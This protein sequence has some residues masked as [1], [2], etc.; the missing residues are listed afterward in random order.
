ME[1]QE[2]EPLPYQPSLGARLLEAWSW[3]KESKSIPL[4]GGAALQAAVVIIFYPLEFLKK[5]KKRWTFF[6]RKRLP[7]QI[8]LIIS[9]L[10]HP[11]R[12]QRSGPCCLPLT[13]ILSQ[14]HRL[15]AA[16]LL[17]SHTAVPE[18]KQSYV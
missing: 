9:C 11:L 6:R 7:K 13:G 12:K 1:I 17:F 5:P 15:R 4:V 14:D 16:M 2:H 18:S 8:P 3:L 10:N